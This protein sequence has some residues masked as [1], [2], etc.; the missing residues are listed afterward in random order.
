MP[1]TSEALPKTG[2]TNAFQMFLREQRLSPKEGSLEWKAMDSK[3]PVLARRN[4]ALLFIKDKGE[5]KE[6]AKAEREREGQGTLAGSLS[7]SRRLRAQV[8]YLT[9][10]Q[11]LRQPS[12]SYSPDT[13][14]RNF[15]NLQMFQQLTFHQKMAST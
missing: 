9:W 14:G 8:I 5:Y 12:Y 6:K 1:R 10:N 15:R 4:C 3:V 7:C 11:N 2:T 13:Y